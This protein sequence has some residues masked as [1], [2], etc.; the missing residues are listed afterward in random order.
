MSSIR[1]PTIAREH[2]SR[3]DEALDRDHSAAKR[4]KGEQYH[5]YDSKTR[6]TTARV[7]RESGLLQGHSRAHL[8]NR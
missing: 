3:V 2:C 6:L 1:D 4:R 5:V 7:A 8:Q